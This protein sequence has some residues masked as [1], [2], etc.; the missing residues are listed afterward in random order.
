[1]DK[2]CEMQDAGGALCIMDSLSYLVKRA[3]GEDR[4]QLGTCTGYKEIVALVC[5]SMLV[6][7]LQC[8]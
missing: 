1:M 7:S 5:S 2:L 3:G 6:G 8:V 4:V